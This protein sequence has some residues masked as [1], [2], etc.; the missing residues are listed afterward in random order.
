MKL[1]VV[2]TLIT[3]AASVLILFGGWLL[4]NQVAID[5]PLQKAVKQVDGIAQADTPVLDKDVVSIQLTLEPDADL[6]AIYDS[7]KEKGKDI[8]GNR[9]LQLTITNSDTSQRLEKVW[10]SALFDIAQAMET[11]QYSNIPA[12][13]TQIAKLNEGVQFVTDMDDKNVYITL[14]D[15]SASKYVV[16]PRESAQLEVS[17]YA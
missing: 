8:I 17:T 14:K 1:R 12:S 3:V 11:K 6:K 5:A 2:P 9:E 13:L 16:L 4:Y 15:G 7:I 10:S